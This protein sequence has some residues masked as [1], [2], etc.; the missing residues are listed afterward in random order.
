MTAISLG[1]A[2]PL[3]GCDRCFG[4]M[5][6]GTSDPFAQ[7]EGRIVTSESGRGVDGATVTLI[8]ASSSASDSV[9]TVTDDEGLFSLR[10]DVAD[11]SARLALRV[12]PSGKPGF[13][14][15]TL[16]CAAQRRA[17][18][19]CVLFP[20]AELP[21]LPAFH[22]RYR[23]DPAK[24]VAGAAVT[25]VRTGGTQLVGVFGAVPDTQFVGNT[26]ADGFL[27]LFSQGTFAKSLEPLV[28]ELVVELPPPYGEVRRQNY[29]L[30]PNY[31][32]GR[33][34]IYQM[35]GPG[36]GYLLTFQDS[37]TSLPVADVVVQFDRTGG[38]GIKPEHFETVGTPTGRAG[39]ELYPAA[40]GTVVGDLT[41][42]R[43]KTGLPNVFPGIALTTFDGDTSL[44]FARFHVGKTGVFYRVGPSP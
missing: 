42:R 24:P 33:S 37:A 36:L 4:V 25:F 17:G 19:A 11:P 16:P 12:Q 29:A 20:I 34:D 40:P 44:V 7:V 26:A 3:G 39:F 8:A 41:L 35:V 30:T 22:F 28:G 13:L 10:L 38:I 1:F 32:F 14:I 9:R 43:T 27:W 31:W 23:N 18:E 21:T 6:C 5:G 2:V 15:D